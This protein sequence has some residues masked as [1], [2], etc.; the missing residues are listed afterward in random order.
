VDRGIDLEVGALREAGDMVRSAA[1]ASAAPA[2]DEARA[3]ITRAA[4]AR[5]SVA[6]A[7]KA[8]FFM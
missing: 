4:S 2:E 8:G 3:G 5:R 6:E 7:P 1:G